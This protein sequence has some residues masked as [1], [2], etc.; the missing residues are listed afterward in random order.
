MK[1]IEMTGVT[2][3]KIINDGEIH[4]DGL[5]EAGVEASTIVRVN[6][7]GDIEVRRP[8]GWDIIGGLLGEYVVRVQDQTGLNWAE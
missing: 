6:E 2:L 1:F 4:A 5:R 7:H 8:E 3:D